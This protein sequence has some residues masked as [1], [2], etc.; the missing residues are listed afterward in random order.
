MYCYFYFFHF[1]YEYYFCYYY[2]YVFTISAAAFFVTYDTSKNLLTPLCAPGFEPVAHMCAA[3][4]GEV[5]A[6][7]IRVPVEVVKQ[8]TQAEPG[9]SSWNTLKSTLAKEGAGGLFRGYGSTVLREIPFSLIQFP[10]WE[11]LKVG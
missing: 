6:C 7:L 8:R 11:A 9:S 5:M 10:I 2:R 4:L 1:E 3:S